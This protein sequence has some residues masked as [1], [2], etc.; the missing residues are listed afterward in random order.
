LEDEFED[1]EFDPVE[2][3]LAEVATSSWWLIKTSPDYAQVLDELQGSAF[4][5][6]YSFGLE[7]INERQSI[8]GASTTSFYGFDGHGSVRLLTS[9]TGAVT[10]TY[11][12]DAFGTKI[13]S[14]GSTPNNDLFAGEQ[15][16]PA[17]GIYY[18]RARYYDQ[19]QGRFWTMD[20]FEGSEFDPFEPA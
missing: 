3:S 9:S 14:T 4:S 15:F 11:D 5:R 12:Y 17:L 1:S 18:N 7:L 6:T 13:S 10:D 16:D 19:R 2:E 20:E 8:A